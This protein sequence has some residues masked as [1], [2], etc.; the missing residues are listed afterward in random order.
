MLAEFDAKCIRFNQHAWV[1]IINLDQYMVTS[2]NLIWSNRR[3]REGKISFCGVVL[4]IAIK[5]GSQ[6]W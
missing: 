2:C 5:F 3:D 1:S 6:N 4:K